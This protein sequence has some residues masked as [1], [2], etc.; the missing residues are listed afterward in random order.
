MATA[1]SSPNKLLR[2]MVDANTLV[3]GTAWPRF[4]YEVLQHAVRGDFRLV[5]S[6]EIIGEARY[7]LAKIEPSSIN[8][9]AFEEF[10]AT[11]LYELVPTPSDEEINAYLNLIRDP[12]DVH[13]ALA[14]I[15]AQVDFLLTQDKDFTDHDESTELLHKLLKVMLPGTF[16]REHMGWTSD[17]LE[18]IRRRMWSDLN[19]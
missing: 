6:E 8:V 9:G 17:Q 1:P 11:T 13:V 10:L 15:N 18:A 16:L 19:R 4:P 3:S 14:A 2:V 7:S 12:D 5:L